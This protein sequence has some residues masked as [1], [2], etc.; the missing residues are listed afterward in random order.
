MFS[1]VYFDTNKEMISI[2]KN[3]KQ[4]GYITCN[5][6]DVC[7]KELMGLGRAKKYRYIE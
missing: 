2:V 3:L 6:Q 5:S 7:H 4:L 1:G